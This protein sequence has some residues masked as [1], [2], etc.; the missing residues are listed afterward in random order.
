LQ[1]FVLATGTALFAYRW[2]SKP[3]TLTIA[4]GSLDSE[5]GKVM[6]A[7]AAHLVAMNASVRLKAVE[8]G[9]ALEAAKAFAS[10][11]TDL[12]VVRGDVATCRRRKPSSWWPKP[13]HC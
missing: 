13:W 2:Y 9:S 3:D 5:A 10:G 6:S 11:K 8:T 1:A 12:A 4:V 7:I